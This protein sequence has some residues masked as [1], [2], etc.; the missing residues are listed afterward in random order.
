MY[1]LRSVTA[2]C[3]TQT[4][5]RCTAS[6]A[7]TART[8]WC[9]GTRSPGWWPRSAPRCGGSGP[10]TAWAWAASWA[11]A[12]PAPAARPVISSTV[13]RGLCRH[14]TGLIPQ[15][16]ST[17]SP[18]AVTQSLLQLTRTLFSKSQRICQWMLGLHY[19]ALVSQCGALWSTLKE[20]KRVARRLVLLAL[21]ASGIWVSSL[22]KQWVMRSLY[23]Q[24]LQERKQILK[25]LALRL[26]SPRTRRR[27]GHW[28]T[29]WT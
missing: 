11:A 27:C 23:F 24:H 10:A 17:Q 16:Q 5:T 13:M 21:E 28:A 1:T 7:G 20:P 4:T 22:P 15:T 3:A 29:P 25:P 2:G 19:F 26:C 18:L 12:A 14:T 9:P 6:G 8:R